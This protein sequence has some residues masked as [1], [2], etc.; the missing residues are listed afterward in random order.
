MKELLVAL[1]S[2]DVNTFKAAGTELLTR[3][4]KGSST[5]PSREGTVGRSA[6][7]TDSEIFGEGV[8][9]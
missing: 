4:D 5:R 8:N 3:C 6:T 2:R 9:L 1:F 7:T